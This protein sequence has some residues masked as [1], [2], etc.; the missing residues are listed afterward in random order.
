MNHMK[1]YFFGDYNKNKLE[2]RTKL[3]HL[4]TNQYHTKPCVTGAKAQISLPADPS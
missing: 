1:V 3:T 4:D 2:F